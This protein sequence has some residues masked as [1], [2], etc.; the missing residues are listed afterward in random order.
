MITLFE[1]SNDAIDLMLIRTNPFPG[2]ADSIQRVPSIR[3]HLVLTRH[4]FS[5]REVKEED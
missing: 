2:N 4:L 1:K 5:V 3:R